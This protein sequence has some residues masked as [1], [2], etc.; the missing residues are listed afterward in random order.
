MEKIILQTERLYL[1]NFCEQDLE[2]LYKIYSEDEVMKYI[3]RGGALNKEQSLKMINI[4][5]EKFYKEKNYCI[6][7]L[8]EKSGGKLIGHCGFSDLPENYGTEIAY[9]ISREYW[10]KGYATEIA[11]ETLKYGFEILNFKTIYALSYPQNKASVN[12]LKK[13]GMKQN[14]ILNLY[15]ID[16]LYFKKNK[17]NME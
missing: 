14:G 2:D 1:R 7:A 10:N 17:V 6:W 15:G 12:V 11:M 4:Q 3:G 5:S 13:I 9:L 8:A 16:F